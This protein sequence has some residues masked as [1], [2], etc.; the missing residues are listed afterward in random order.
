MRVAGLSGGSMT[1]RSE[2]THTDT[3]GGLTDV[4]IGSFT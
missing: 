4:R 2:K 1:V 3:H